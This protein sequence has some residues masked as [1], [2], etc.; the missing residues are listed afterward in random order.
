MQSFAYQQN[1]LSMLKK[2]YIMRKN[3]YV[4]DITESF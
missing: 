1:N 3:M 4:N 2:N